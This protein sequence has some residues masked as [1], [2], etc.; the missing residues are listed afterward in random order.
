MPM[1]TMTPE[2]TDRPW[3]IEAPAPMVDSAPIVTFPEMLTLGITEQKSPSTES[4]PTWEPVLMKTHRPRLMSTDREQKCETT[5]PSSIAMRE[6]S[7][8]S[9]SMT[10]GKRTWGQRFRASYIACLSEGRAMERAFFYN[11]VEYSIHIFS[12]LS[13]SKSSYCIARKIF[14]HFT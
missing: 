4:C 1:P 10:F 13:N 7:F 14:I 5:T 3:R 2:P 12:W 8:E 11:I 9:V 6:E